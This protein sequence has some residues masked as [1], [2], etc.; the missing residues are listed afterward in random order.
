MKA[1]L[2]CAAAIAVTVGSCSSNTSAPENR[3]GDTA[4]PLAGFGA[5]PTITSVL[6]EVQA[7]GIVVLATASDPQ[8]SGNLVNVTQEISVFRDARCESPPITVK[9]DLAGSGIEESFG[10]AV[11]AA[12]E[13]DLYSR[14]AS[15][16]T[17]PVAVDFRDADGNRTIGR[18]RASVVK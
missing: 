7:G 5:A 12:A 11:Q 13:P 18:V 15:A 17:W 8:G 4:L 14:I 6:L 16:S 10:T 3:C 2:L 9:D 1:Q